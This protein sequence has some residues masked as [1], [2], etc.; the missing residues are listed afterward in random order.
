MSYKAI[1]TQESEPLPQ[2]LDATLTS[3]AEI[4]T[5]LSLMLLRVVER[6]VA[7]NFT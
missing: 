2:F 5:G 7:V 3:C 1:N 4:D 6:A